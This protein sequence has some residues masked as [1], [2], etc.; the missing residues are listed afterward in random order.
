MTVSHRPGDPEYRNQWLERRHEE[1]VE[2]IG[3]MNIRT[4]RAEAKA[5][6]LRKEVAKLTKILERSLPLAVR[7][8]I[9]WDS[10]KRTSQGGRG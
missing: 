1:M 2:K 6:F 3:A 5:R 7:L 10:R 8:A 4:Q 9:W